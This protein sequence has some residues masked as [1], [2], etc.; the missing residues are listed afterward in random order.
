MNFNKIRA[1]Y[2]GPTHYNIPTLRKKIQLPIHDTKKSMDIYLNNHKYS[3]E[4]YT[5]QFGKP[6]L[7]PYSPLNKCGSKLDVMS[8][9]TVQMDMAMKL[10]ANSPFQ[11]D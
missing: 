7:E 4:F 2:M 6:R 10:F 9:H 5:D 11:F 3:V 1:T 8:S